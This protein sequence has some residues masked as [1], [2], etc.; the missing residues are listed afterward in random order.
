MRL[1]YCL[2][3][4]DAVRLTF[5]LRTQLFPEAKILKRAPPSR[6]WAVTPGNASNAV[7]LPPVGA[8]QRY[9]RRGVNLASLTVVIRVYPP[10]PCCLRCLLQGF[11]PLNRQ[12]ES[13]APQRYHR[14]GGKPCLLDCCHKGFPPRPSSVV[15]FTLHKPSS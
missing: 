11:G 10:K 12:I 2:F 1:R 13:G 14:Q 3:Q 6:F 4:L 8:L 5:L 15:R 9:H 7:A